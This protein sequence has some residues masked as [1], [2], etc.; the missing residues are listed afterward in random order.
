MNLNGKKYL[1]YQQSTHIITFV[2][3]S[4]FEIIST[5]GIDAI[6][7]FQSDF[8]TLLHTYIHECA[9]QKMKRGAVGGREIEKYAKI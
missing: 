9:S 7:F 1:I 8:S 2:S 4:V 5:L 3:L 6:T